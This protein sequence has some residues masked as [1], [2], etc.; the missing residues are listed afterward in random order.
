MISYDDSMNSLL[1]Q[2]NKTLDISILK[3]FNSQVVRWTGQYVENANG[4]ETAVQW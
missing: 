2:G 1:K 3:I 4:N